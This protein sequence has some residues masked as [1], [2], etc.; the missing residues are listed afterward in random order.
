MANRVQIQEFPVLPS[1]PQDPEEGQSNTHVLAALV[2][3]P[4]SVAVLAL[5]AL[6][7]TGTLIGLSLALPLFIIFSPIIV[8]AVIAISLLV[9]GFLS[10]GAFGFMGVLSLGYGLK[11]LVNGND[12]DDTE[13]KQPGIL[14]AMR[15]GDVG[16]KNEDVEQ[17]T[18]DVGQKTEDVEQKTEDGGQKTENNAND[19]GA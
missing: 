9:A 3:I 18:E 17:K 10:S 1:Q 4:L 11:R 16:Q 13:S 19:G 12:D 7:L 14:Q 15:T 2:L 6:M 8:P 5:A